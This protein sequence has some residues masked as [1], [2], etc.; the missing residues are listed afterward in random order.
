MRL[1]IEKN[2]TEKKT[3][4]G[5]LFR[6]DDGFKFWVARTNVEV[7]SSTLYS[8]YFNANWTIKEAGRKGEETKE[9]SIPE[10]RE[11]YTDLVWEGGR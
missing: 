4:K 8:V 11:K 5:Q 6:L 3:E 2:K 9:Y 1:I 10:F 7:E